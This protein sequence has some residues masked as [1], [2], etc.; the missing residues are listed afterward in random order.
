MTE[1]VH[2]VAIVGV[3]CAA[4]R[5]AKAGITD[6]VVLDDVD[7]AGAVF[8]EQTH[9]WPLPSCRAR[10]VVTD[11]TR[12]GREGLDPYLGVAAHGVPNY[13]TVTGSDPVA[14]ARLD[15]V[16]ECLTLMWRDRATRIEV[17]FST[18]R[19]FHLRGT[20][21]AERADA[22]FWQ[23][24]VA[25]APTAFDFSSHIGV[26]EEVYDGPARLRLGDD[27]REVRVR[28]SGRLDPIDGRYHWQGTILDPL[29]DGAR[30]GA[31]TMTIGEHTADCRLTERTQQGGYSVA[32][33]GT[34]PYALDDVE[35]VVP[36]R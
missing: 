20:D 24:M 5:F 28:L 11:Q 7:L 30:L 36:L 6:I 13:F 21:R 4:Q 8:D 12:C 25:A 10:I 3:D 27:E 2:D 23:R 19:T 34:P 16:A 31:A 17:R 15:F 35:V 22:S 32:G 9:T 1:P 26:A 33:V 18:Q 14:D 29:F